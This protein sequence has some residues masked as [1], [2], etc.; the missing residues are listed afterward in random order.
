MML[1][2]VNNYKFSLRFLSIEIL[3]FDDTKVLVALIAL[4][5]N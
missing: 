2:F 1:S 3:S 5:N 4:Q